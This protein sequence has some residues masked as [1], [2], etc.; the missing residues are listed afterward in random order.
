MFLSRLFSSNVCTFSHFR[1]NSP[2][3]FHALTDCNPRKPIRH[4]HLS[5]HPGMASFKITGSRA[6]G[7]ERRGDPLDGK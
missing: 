2:L 3:Y 6:A 7:R 4:T 1:K 5:K